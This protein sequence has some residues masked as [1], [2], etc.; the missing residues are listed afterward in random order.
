MAKLLDVERNFEKQ[1]TTDLPAEEL[2]E[3]QP[4]EDNVPEKYKGKST[5]DIIQMH[6]EAEKLLG[7]QS[8][9]VGELRKVVDNYIQGQTQLKEDVTRQSEE[10]V[11]FFS[12]PEK[13]IQQQIA[14][15]P[16]ILEAEKISQQYQQET[17][18]AQLNKLHPDMNKIVQDK[19]FQEWVTASKVRQK[20]FYQADKMY[21]YETADELLNLWKDRQQTVQQTAQTEKKERKQIVKSAS[22]GTTKGSTAPSS[23]KIYRRADIIKLM[24]ED[25][26]RY[27]ALSGEIMQAYAERR[28]R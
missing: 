14:K 13:A 15:H 21:D 18:K 6:Q 22:T 24:K 20:L 9:E 16:K 23:K 26:D 5:S 10:E 12:D 4:P 1:E 25:P 27:Q 17:A 2:I 3:E 19:K 28:V 7:K 11:D 8:S